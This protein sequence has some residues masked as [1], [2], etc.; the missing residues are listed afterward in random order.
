MSA[1]VH[2]QRLEFRDVEAEEFK[3]ILDRSDIEHT[4][5]GGQ[6]GAAEIEQFHG[7]AFSLDRGHYG[8]PVVVRGQFAPGCI[9][10]GMVKGVK[11]PTW[12]NGS[13]TARG[14]LQFYSEGAD[15]LYRAGPEANWAG[16]T[17]T[18]ERLQAEARK[19]LGKELALPDPGEMEH[20]RIDP[21]AFDRLARLIRL[22]R[23][24]P[25]GIS[26][27]RDAEASAQ[28]VLGAYAEAIA[29]TDPSTAGAIRTRVTR[30]NQVVRRADALM[31]SLV[32]RNY[33]SARVCKALGMSERNLELYFR[34]AL[35]VSPKAWFHHLCL[36]RARAMLRHRKGH[37]TDVALACGFEHFGRFAEGY[38]KLFGERPSETLRS[39]GSPKPAAILGRPA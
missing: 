32:G 31:R 7:Q 27:F 5:I 13:E 28:L 22:L 9:C 6:R 30:R 15:I 11:V 17:V 18:R 3:E 35:G 38:R 10:I 21:E 2:Y 33:S 19:R 14:D 37:V 29:T 25:N 1:R 24:A 20:L 4:I 8:F 26:P 12:I 36:H 34:E 16:L 39:A 23:P